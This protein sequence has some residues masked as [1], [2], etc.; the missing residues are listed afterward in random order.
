MNQFEDVVRTFL[1]LQLVC[2]HPD[3]YCKYGLYYHERHAVKTLLN[4]EK[5]CENI[6]AFFCF[7]H[8]CCSSITSIKTMLSLTTTCIYG[9][10]CKFDVKWAVTYFFISYFA[11]LCIQQYSIFLLYVTL[12]SL[13][14]TLNS[15]IY[16]SNIALYVSNPPSYIYLSTYSN[17]LVV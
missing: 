15:F 7:D 6:F 16:I 2:Q 9:S 14:V 8:I 5:K 13:N 17:I 11:Y 12:I 3:N 4:W 10:D 1:Y